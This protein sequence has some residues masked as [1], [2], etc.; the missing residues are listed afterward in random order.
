MLKV[1]GECEEGGRIIRLGNLFF[2]WTL[3]LGGTDLAKKKRVNYDKLKI[4]TKQLK[5][6]I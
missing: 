5:S 6:N 3:K 4:A 2:L 1:E